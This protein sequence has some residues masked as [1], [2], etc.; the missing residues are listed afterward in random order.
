MELKDEK[1]HG[2][3]RRGTSYLIFFIKLSIHLYIE[4]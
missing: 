3:A 1:F 4:N 2:S